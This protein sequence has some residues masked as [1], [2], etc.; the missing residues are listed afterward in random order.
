MTFPAQ[1][2]PE[3]QALLDAEL[4]AGNRVAD[5]GPSPH[6]PQGVLVLLAADFKNRPRVRPAGVDYVEI[7]DPHWWKAEYVHR[8]S[9]HVLAARFDSA[10]P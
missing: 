2:C 6:H 5:R 3:L 1:L 8:P 4:A 10:S 9:G 7:N